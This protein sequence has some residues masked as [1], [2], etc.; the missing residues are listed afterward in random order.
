MTKQTTI[1]LT[2]EEII[3]NKV[4]EVLNKSKKVELPKDIIETD[5]I[6]EVIEKNKIKNYDR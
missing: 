6:G 5:N 1:G 2:I 4:H 3:K